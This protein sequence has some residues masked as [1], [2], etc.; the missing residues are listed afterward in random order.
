M[1]AISW[2]V[3]VFDGE[4]DYVGQDLSLI[5]QVEGETEISGRLSDWPTTR[6]G[7]HLVCVLANLNYL[8][9]QR[10]PLDRDARISSAMTVLFDR[11]M[12]SNVSVAR[13]DILME[14]NAVH[15]SV[16]AT[17]SPRFD[18]EPFEVADGDLAWELVRQLLLRMFPQYPFR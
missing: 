10:Y 15:A 18:I 1:M 9:K 16:L 17:G 13:F 12:N 4:Y 14:G 5:A 2:R 6:A 8:H 11:G 7:R 3:R